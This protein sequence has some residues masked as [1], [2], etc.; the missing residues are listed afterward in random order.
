[1]AKPKRYFGGHGAYTLV[2][3][4]LTKGEAANIGNKIKKENPEASVRAYPEKDGMYSLYTRGWK[5]TTKKK[6]DAAYAANRASVEKMNKA[7]RKDL[8]PWAD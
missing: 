3:S 5:Q 2:K 8:P 4:G 7:F 6:K 1:M